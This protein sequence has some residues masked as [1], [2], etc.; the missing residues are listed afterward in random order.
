MLVFSEEKPLSEADLKTCY[1]VISKNRELRGMIDQL[2]N[3]VKTVMGL[4][5]KHKMTFMD[6]AYLWQESR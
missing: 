2:M 5:N 4:A 6:H 3:R 1:G